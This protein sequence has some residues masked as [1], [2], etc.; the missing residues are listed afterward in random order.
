MPAEFQQHVDPNN[1]MQATLIQRGHQLQPD[2]SKAF[3]AS[4]DVPALNVLKHLVPELNFLW[5][6]I[7][8]LK[9]QGAPGGA[10]G[11]SP[12]AP[13]P[14]SGAPPMPAPQLPQQLPPRLAA[15][16]MPR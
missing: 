11:Q 14:A 15:Q 7:I 6:K 5:D 3:V 4:I 10:P 2:E 16:T 9:G 8:Q 12:G 1:Q 13:Q